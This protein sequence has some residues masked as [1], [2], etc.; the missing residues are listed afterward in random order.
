MPYIR[1][2]LRNGIIKASGSFTTRQTPLIRPNPHLSCFGG[3]AR[4]PASSRLIKTRRLQRARVGAVRTAS[5]HQA[6]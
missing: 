1:P 5:V 6:R 2:W 4:S 3:T